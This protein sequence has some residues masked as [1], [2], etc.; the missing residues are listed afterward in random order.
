MMLRTNRTVA[1]RDDTPIALE[2]PAPAPEKVASTPGQPRTSEL[3]SRVR[4]GPRAA[5]AGDAN[6]EGMDGRDAAETYETSSR[7]LS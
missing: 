5:R 2:R 3:P 7:H 1:G 6:R 4:V